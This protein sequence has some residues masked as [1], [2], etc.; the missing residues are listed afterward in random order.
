[1]RTSALYG[2]N[3]CRAKG[4][5][6]F[7]ELMLKLAGERDE[8]R[9]VDDEIISPTSTADVARQIALLTRT[10]CYGLYH[11]TSEGSCSWYEFAKT[12][13]EMT[14]MKMNLKIAAANEFPMKVPR[15]KY[16][17]LENGGLKS[18]GL[19]SFPRWEEGLRAYL[20]ATNSARA[21]TALI[22]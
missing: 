4:G 18:E 2:R 1:V 15:P 17:V 3:P 21:A 8:L 19:N 5:R 11:A 20:S 16:S 6:N 7:V 10:D 12:I 14:H 9:V 13:F 22:G